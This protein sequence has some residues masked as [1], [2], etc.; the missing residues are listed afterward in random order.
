MQG[1]IVAQKELGNVVWFIE[2][3]VEAKCNLFVYFPYNDK[4]ICQYV[5]K[6]A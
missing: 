2:F 1:I 4:S 6:Q 5:Q 3:D